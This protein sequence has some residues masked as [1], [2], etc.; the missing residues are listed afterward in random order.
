MKNVR[1]QTHLGA[2][3]EFP[4]MNEASLRMVLKDLTPGRTLT[5]I[6]ESGA[7][8]SMPGR[9]IKELSC[10]DVGE[11]GEVLWTSPA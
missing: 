5:M 4:D 10:G 8:L 7:Y 2:Y 6:N 3:Y 11:P 1:I 9:I